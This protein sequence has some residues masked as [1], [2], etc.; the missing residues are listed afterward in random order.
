MEPLLLFVVFV[1][2]AVLGYLGWQAEKR[3]RE[4][5]GQWAAAHGWKY[6][7]HRDPSIRLRYGF[8]DRLQVGHSRM[9]TVC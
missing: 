5:F 6:N 2:I 8:L 7:H 3:R 9:G 1:A 4:E